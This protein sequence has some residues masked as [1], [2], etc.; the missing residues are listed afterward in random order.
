MKYKVTEKQIV[1]CLFFVSSSILSKI[2]LN[3]K[4]EAIL[5]SIHLSYCN[6]LYKYELIC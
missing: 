4:I 5:K 2:R 6:E 1:S 3:V